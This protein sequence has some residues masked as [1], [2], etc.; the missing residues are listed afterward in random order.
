MSNSLSALKEQRQAITMYQPTEN[1]SH[2]DHIIFE[3]W[4]TIPMVRIVKVLSGKNNSQ[5]LFSIRSIAVIIGKSV[6]TVSHAINTLVENG[7]LSRENGAIKLNL[8]GVQNP[9]LSVQESE[10]LQESVQNIEQGVQKT[11]Q[12][13]QKTEQMCSEFRTHNINNNINKNINNRIEA[14]ASNPSKN[15][16]VK[17]NNSLTTTKQPPGYREDTKEIMP[18]VWLKPNEVTA[19]VEKFGK[20]AVK[21]KMLSISTGIEDG[22]KTYTRIKNHSLAILKWF[23]MDENKINLQVAI[24]QKTQPK[25]FRQ[26]DDEYGDQVYEDFLKEQ[27]SKK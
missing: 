27:G 2:L 21:A 23:S 6:G 15:Q 19:L 5:R 13:V 8:S 9:E 17:F 24:R 20:P 12:S 4:A 16:L 18:N 11:E 26:M 1:Q 7:Y 3:D 14:S 10:H 25:T 22:V